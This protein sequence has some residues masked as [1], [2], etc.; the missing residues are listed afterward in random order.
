MKRYWSVSCALLTMPLTMLLT[1]LLTMMLTVLWL[2]PLAQQAQA[3][4]ELEQGPSI[5]ISIQNL[6]EQFADVKHVMQKAGF[7]FFAPMVDSSS[8]EYLVGID[9][10]QPVCISM[11]F[12]ESEEEPRVIGFVPVEEIDDVLDT[13]ADF[14]DIEE[15]GDSIVITTDNGQSF[16]VKEADG[17]AIFSN[18]SE[19]LKTAPTVPTALLGDLPGRYNIAVKVFG[20]RIPAEMREQAI[21][22]MRDSFEQTL[23]NM[24]EDD[25]ASEDSHAQMKALEDLINETEELVI[26]LDIDEDKGSL[27][28]DISI[29]GIP[30][31]KLAKQST[32]AGKNRTQFSGFLADDAAFSANM[33]YTML[34]ED[35]EQAKKS[36]DQG[37][38]A[39]LD[40]LAEQVSEDEFE[41]IDDLAHDLIDIVKDTM[42]DGVVDLGII[43]YVDADQFNVA[44]GSLNSNPMKYEAT[45]RKAIKQLQDSASE[46]G[47]ELEVKYNESSHAGIQ[48][49]KV[50][51][52]IPESEDEVRD[53]L[54]EEL[55][56]YIGIGK[57]ASYIA[58]GQNP[59]ELL[60]KAIDASKN[61]SGKLP[62]FQ[63]TVSLTPILEFMY[64]LE[65]DEALMKM[66]ESLKDS[67]SDMIKLTGDVIPNG[68]TLRFELQDG[69]LKTFGVLG[70]QMGGGGMG[71]EDF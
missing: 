55:A 31:S 71:G 43:G 68:Q 26:G 65:Q 59:K 2:A 66:V 7:G 41:V 54:G 13:I 9:Q 48:F 62:A 45:V 57:K 4:S 16:E 34:P 10:S 49:H 27:L 24:D 50:V 51:A 8:Q 47:I 67:D 11:Y 42:D 52:P 46:Q 38:D 14:A 33:C 22:L 53:I 30:G 23:D 36:V 21:E 3:Q 6:E 60:I 32:V 12:R 18:D 69:I 35:I 5:V 64:L 39:A 63:T 1:K 70:A 20:Q 44:M 61:S 37:L 40:Q 28:F 58:F 15:D 56:I 25:A 17:Y 19:L 29:V